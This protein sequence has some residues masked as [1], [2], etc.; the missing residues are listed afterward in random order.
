MNLCLFPPETRE[1]QLDEMG[2][3]VAKKQANCDLDDPA[4]DHKGDWWD[5]VVDDAEPRLVLT[6]VPGAHSVEN[7][8]EA[9][10]EAY[11]RSISPNTATISAGRCGRCESQ[12]TTGDITSGRPRWRPV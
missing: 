3:F 7:T 8:E 1:I 9:V 2:S 11:D 12:L 10:A 5:Y 6:V 4:D